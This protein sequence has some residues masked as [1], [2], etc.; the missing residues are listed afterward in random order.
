MVALGIKG[1][2]I[3]APDPYSAFAEGESGTRTGAD[4]SFTLMMPAEEDRKVDIL[5]ERPLVV[6]KPGYAAG[7]AELK[8][9]PAGPAPVAV[10][11]TRGIELAGRVRS[12][13]GAPLPGVAVTL[14]EDGTIFG[15][16]IASHFLLTFLKGD[17]W[18]TT[19]AAG[20][21]AVR[22]HP[23]VHHLAFRG[24]GVAPQVVRGYDPRGGEA[25][26]VVLE[27]AATL[28]GRV[29]R[30]DGR[31][32][33]DVTI[34]MSKPES[35]GMQEDTATTGA[36]GRFEVKDLAGGEYE[37]T[38]VH[39]KLGIHETRT[40]EVPAADWQLVLEASGTLRGHVVDAANRQPV[41]AFHLMVAWPEEPSRPA[42]MRQADIEDAA[43]A[44]ELLD[45]PARD[46]SV[47][48]TADGYAPR[49]IEGV[50]VPAGAEG[51]EVEVVL[52]ADAPLG[53]RVT[54]EDK[55]SVSEATVRL[56]TKG[57][58][59]GATAMV[60]DRGEYELRGVAPGEVT[61]TFQAQGFLSEKKTL[62]TR[63]TTRLDVTLRRGLSLTGVVVSEGA[64]V[65]GAS[66]SASSSAV[67]AQ[68]AYVR[69]DEQGRFKLEGLVAGRYRVSASADG[70]GSV[71]LDDVDPETAGVLRLVLERAQHATV[72]GKV[73]GLTPG[74]DLVFAEVKASNEDGEQSSALVDGSSAFRMEDAPA[75]RITVVA[76]ANTLVAMRQ[77]R[78]VEVTLAPGAEAEVVLEFPSAVVSGQ[79]TRDGRPVPGLAVSFDGTGV[80]AARGRT[81][82]RGNYEVAGLESGRYKVSVSGDGSSFETEYVVSGSGEFDI[83]IT[84]GSVR[85]RTV[86]TDGETPVSG[87]E[88]ALWPAGAHE[89]RPGGSATTNGQGEFSL[90]SLREGRYRLTTSKAGF[91]QEVRELDVARGAT[92]TVLLELSPA[93]GVSVSVVDARDGRA[94]EATVVVRDLGRR[95]VANSHSG[96]DDEGTLNIPLADGSYLLSTS[97]SGY[98]TA[99]VPVTAP[100]QGLR[101]GLTPG[102]TL[103]VESA[104]DLQGHLRLVQPDGEDYVQCWCNGIADIELTGRRT[105][106]EH[107]TPGSYTLEVLDGAEEVLA[108]K[109]VVIR[110]GQKTVVTIE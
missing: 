49:R 44:F 24:A 106:V 82:V 81:D 62:D 99:T 94:L 39:A 29:V 8:A 100:S 47:R 110:E 21:F 35:M 54:A 97:A 19:D 25:L 96:V 76:S 15:S 58:G 33:P 71:K 12:P 43:G 107:V 101:L 53:G 36:D 13:G 56:V 73:V 51:A 109:P 14:A 2:H 70:K 61:L 28:R 77:S 50:A 46:L 63:Q 3:Y 69:S 74:D 75:G 93:A 68:H 52:D 95:I 80:A 23:A 79:V 67:N 22:V 59:E 91:G 89:N 40:V 26:E 5:K 31:A 16:T 10:T 78:P 102:G 66:V 11:L 4:G 108:R 84:G 85:G 9:G 60:D 6:L 27:P 20:R 32:V 37:L 41:K 104:R 86:R 64:G 72:T 34:T 90:R 30:P 42:G 57:D 65:P 88:I 103:V 105:T 18:T 45:V 38:A 98:G 55:S 7:R 83:D 1:P 92:A 17:G 48:A 87:V